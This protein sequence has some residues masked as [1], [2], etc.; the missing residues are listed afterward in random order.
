MSM[1]LQGSNC[2]LLTSAALRM[3]VP[4]AVVAEVLGPSFLEFARDESTGLEY[5]GWRG[6]RVPLLGSPAAGTAHPAPD[7]DEHRDFGEEAKIAIFHGLKHQQLLPYYG[8][9]ITRSPRLLRVAEGDLEEVTGVPLQPAELMRIRVDGGEACIPKVD[10]F[11]TTL[12]DLMK[13]AAAR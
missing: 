13:P 7:S 8:F 6:R 11:E 9:V 4:R 1:H 5:F 2:L 10:H 3:L 12:I